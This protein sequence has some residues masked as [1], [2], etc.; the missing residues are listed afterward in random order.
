MPCLQVAK[1]V[2]TYVSPEVKDL[3]TLLENEFHPLDLAARAEPFL[4][5]LPNLS[6]KLSSASPVPEVR[7]EQYVPALERLTALR[8]LQQ[9]KSC[10]ELSLISRFCHSCILHDGQL[11]DYSKCLEPCLSF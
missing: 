6:D 8:V 1:G 9:V 2:M 3:Y 4:S 10:I 7:L 11:K 5:K